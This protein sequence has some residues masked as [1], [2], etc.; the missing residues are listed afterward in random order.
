MMGLQMMLK[1]MGLDPDEII[2]SVNQF[3]EVFKAMQEQ[4][5]RIENKLDK[6]LVQ[7]LL[8]E[9]TEAETSTGD[10][11]DASHLNGKEMQ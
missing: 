11:A 6:V 8:S 10:D 4:M 9:V 3:G 7:N 1:S 5:N 2:K